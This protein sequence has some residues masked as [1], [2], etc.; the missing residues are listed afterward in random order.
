MQVLGLEIKEVRVVARED[1]R[2]T[3]R[4]HLHTS[5]STRTQVRL[6]LASAH[7]SPTSQTHS[8]LSYAG[9][10]LGTPVGRHRKASPRNGHSQPKTDQCCSA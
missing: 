7:M 2:K 8:L 5:R 1:I 10:E 3:E 9:Q 4:Q 6:A